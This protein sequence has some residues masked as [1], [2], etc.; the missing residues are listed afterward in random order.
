MPVPTRNRI[1]DHLRKH[2]TASVRDLASAFHSTGANVRHHLSVLM[3]ND[4]VEIVGLRKG[5]RGRPVNL[6]SLSERLIGNNTSVLSDAILCEV[7]KD[8]SPDTRDQFLH[9]VARWMGGKSVAERQG[10][11]P[12][13]RLS[14][15][16]EW[17]NSMH[18]Q[19]RWEAGSKGP[20]FVLEHCPYSAII[21]DHPELCLLDRYLLEFRL[22]QRVQQ[23]IKQQRSAKGLLYCEFLVG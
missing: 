21:A 6:Y 3:S 18:Y 5:D 11:P 19:A 10:I 13:R 20:R 22:G 8:K 17:L 16:V 9:S 15:A 1:L 4:Q 23:T 14:D 7:F 2:Q 12:T